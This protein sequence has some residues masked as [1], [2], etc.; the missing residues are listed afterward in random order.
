MSEQV[1]NVY[2][3]M[4]LQVSKKKEQVY[5]AQED[6]ELLQREE[7]EKVMKE[8]LAQR[9]KENDKLQQEFDCEWEVKLKEL[10]EKFER[11]FSRKGSRNKVDK[12][13]NMCL[14]SCML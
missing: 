10:T 11:D 13:R 3:C 12:V 2:Y 4:L 9:A 8:M 7:E 1:L 14:L 5:R 6:L